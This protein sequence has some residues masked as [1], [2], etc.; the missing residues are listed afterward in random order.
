[1]KR[2]EFNLFERIIH[3]INHRVFI[4]L[5]AKTRRKKL[6]NLDFTIISNNCWGGVVYEYFGLEKKSPTIGAYFYADDYI[7]FIKDIKKYTTTPMVMIKPTESKHFLDLQEK[8]QLDIPIGKI[9]DVEIYFLHYKDPLVVKEKWERRC[10]RIN[11]K[12]LIVKFSF[13]G[14]CTDEMIEEFDKL[15]FKK[16]VL[17]VTKEYKNINYAVVIPPSDGRQITNDTFYFNKYINL[18][19]VLN[20]E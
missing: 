12:N 9:E 16:K 8:K 2:N 3:R 7:R 19:K 17:F 5:L 13:M 4:P 6:N 20:N 15:D 18:Y 14:D 11:Y 10:E 1:M